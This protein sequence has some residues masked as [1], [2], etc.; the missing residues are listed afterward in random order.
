MSGLSPHPSL[1]PVVIGGSMARKEPTLRRERLGKTLAKDFELNKYKYLLMV[2][3]VIYFILFAYKPMY[4]LI[5]AFKDYRPNLGF[6]RSRWVGLKHFIDFFN[7]VYFFRLL[8]NTLSI[9]LLNIVFGFPAPILLALLLNEI[10]ST[11]F[12][13]TVQTITYMPYFISLVVVSSLIRTYTASNGLFAQIA[14]ATGGSAK[15]YLMHPQYFYPIYVISDIW[16]GIGWNSI[17]YLAA[18]SGI[19][20]EQYEAARIDGAGR[21]RRMLYIT[22]PNL[23]PT[24]MVLFILRMGGILNVGFEKIILLYNEGIYEVADVISSYVYRRGIIQ[25]AF[26]YA[27]AVG[28]FNSIVNVFFL[29]T[30]NTL[31]RKFTESSLF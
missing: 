27:S 5:I 4:G 14:I 31:S 25:A 19:D 13:K 18:L 20:Q 6:A 9:S 16:Q 12:K 10:R 1:P 26:S 29:V 2:P 8:R 21:F 7:D 3:V 11:F 23:L 15:N 24:I 28:L 30:A 17:I 22:L